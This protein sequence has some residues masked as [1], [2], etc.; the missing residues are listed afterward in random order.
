MSNQVHVFEKA[1]LGLA[2]FRF[3]GMEE[4]RGPLPMPGGGFAGAPGQPMGCCQYCSTG[5]AYCYWLQSADGKKFYVGSE[6]ILKSGD[7]GLRQVV[8]AEQ[9]KQRTAKKEA[10]RAAVREERQKAMQAEI[11]ARR[12]EFNAAYSG[13]LQRADK[14]VTVDAFIAD[15]VAKGRQY[16]RLSPNQVN[17][18]E[19]AIV[20][21]EQTAAA[22]VTS[23][24]VGTVGQRISIPVTVVRVGSFQRPAYGRYGAMETVW[25]VTMTDATGNQIVTKTPAFKETEGESF[26]LAGTIKEHAEYK[27]VK[28]TVVMRPAR[29]MLAPKVGGFKKMI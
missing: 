4:R 6:C 22:Q 1:G 11:D 15:I 9:K 13:L 25:V 24:Y 18:L 19:N 21:H 2:P 12:E 5:I 17:A 3:I 26:V 20:R 14:F 16:A 7:A 23:N 29:K 28:Q 27:G 8:K 10:K